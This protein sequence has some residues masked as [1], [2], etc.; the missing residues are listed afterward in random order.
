MIVQVITSSADKMA[1]TQKE[2]EIGRDGQIHRMYSNQYFI[3]YYFAIDKITMK[4]TK[5]E[6]NLIYYI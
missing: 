6:I 4:P 5:E 1:K 3:F 2:G